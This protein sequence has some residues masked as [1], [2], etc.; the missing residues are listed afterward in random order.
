MP[1]R[2]PYAK[3]LDPED[4]AAE[5]V[6]TAVLTAS[7]LLVAVSARSLASVEETLTL[8]QFRM[9]VVLSTRGPMNISRL[10]AHLD[11]IPST[12]LRMVERLASAGMLTK[13][14]NA[15]SR[16]EIRISLTADGRQVVQEATERRRSEIARIV[17]AMPR[18]QRAALV[19]ALH[20]FNEAGEEPP[21]DEPGTADVDW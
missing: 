10:G 18:P 16:R 1:E 12:A 4:E 19:Q 20:A 7:R 2:A 3:P 9:L 5:E 8:P 15:L 11:V 14:P 17:G 13:E 6:V 21:A